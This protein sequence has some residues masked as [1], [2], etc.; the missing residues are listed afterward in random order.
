MIL[1]LYGKDTFRSRKRLSQMIEKFRHDRDPQGLNVVTLDCQKEKTEDAIWQQLLASPFLAEKRM[2]V[3]E[4]LLV[5][6]HKTLQKELLKRIEA[7]SLP[8]STVILFF[9]TTDKFKTKLAKQFFERLLK[10]TF[11]SSYELLEGPKL[12]GWTNELFTQNSFQI[13]RLA[14][15]YLCDNAGPDTWAID[16]VASQLMAYKE[17]EKSVEISDV[18]KFVKE[19]YD[20]N[21]F[22]IID[23]IVKKNTS[24]VFAQIQQIYNNGE[25]PHYIHAMITRQIRIMLM[26]KDAQSRG[27]NTSD[28]RMAKRLGLH[29]FVVKKT[30]PFL[31]KYS[32][33]QLQDI[34]QKLLDIDMQTKKGQNSPALLIDVLVTKMSVS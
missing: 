5:S 20:D 7:E 4:N 10:E 26:L 1:F 32:L 24:Q 16:S 23:N 30:L 33:A 8:D 25:T 27:E 28:P 13:N 15:K 11:V 14:L 31:Q 12:M 22:N 2:V 3:L 18:K 21:I 34:Q 17:N 9:E 19:K 6:T 29:P